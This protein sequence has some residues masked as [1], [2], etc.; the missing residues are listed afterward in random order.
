VTPDWSHLLQSVS[1]M[2]PIRR[3]AA[4]LP[5][6]TPASLPGSIARSCPTARHCTNRRKSLTKRHWFIPLLSKIN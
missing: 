1:A 5:K 2:S 4:P 6:D 3:A